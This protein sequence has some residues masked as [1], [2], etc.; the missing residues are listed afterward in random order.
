MKKWISLLS[1]LLAVQ[2]VLAAVVNL[3]GEEYGAFQAEDRLLA[4]DRKAVDRLRIEG[5]DNSLLLAR[6]GDKWLLPQ[7]DDFPADKGG[8]DRLLDKLD[9]MKKGWPVATTSG[10]TRRFKVA[11]DQ[12]ERKLGLMSGEQTLAELYVG[13]SPGFRK[14]HVRPADEEAVF[15]TDFNTWEASTKVDDW[16]D[17]AVLAIE[18]EEVVRVDMPGYALTGEG[19]EFRVVGLVEGEDTDRAASRALVRR[20]VGLRVQSLLGTEAKPNYRQDAPD[21]E[22][23]LTRKGGDVLRYSFSKPEED[24]YYVLKRSDLVHYFKVPEFTVDPIKD[25]ARETLVQIT[26]AES[27]NADPDSEPD[28]AAVESTE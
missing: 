8:V 11:D 3:T 20:L 9:A 1:A 25:S 16:I 27:P 24:G 10:A 17:K 7:S 23:M 28:S 13:T 6:R 22:I 26:G 5:G 15:A 12:F 19:G 14:V 18:E 4:F 21:L 2:L